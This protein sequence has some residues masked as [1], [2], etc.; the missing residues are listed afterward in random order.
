MVGVDRE[1]IEHML[2][3]NPGTKEVQQKKRVQG[4]DHNRS[5]NVE[6]AKLTKP[7]ILREAIF[8]TWVANP[9]MVKKHDDS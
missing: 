9:V 6:V 1:V 4:G 5:I 7:G 3:I 8:P 2:M